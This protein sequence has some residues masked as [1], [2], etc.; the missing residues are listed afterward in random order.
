MSVLVLALALQATDV[1][2]IPAMPGPP[3]TPESMTSLAF[4]YSCSF[5][6]GNGRQLNILLERRGGRGFATGESKFPAR[7]TPYSVQV[8]HNNTGADV[9]GFSE[10]HASAKGSQLEL[11]TRD[12]SEI[13][14]ILRVSDD[15]SWPDVD[16][17]SRAAAS[18]SWGSTVD[19]GTSRWLEHR[20]EGEC[21][22]EKLV[23]EP[24]SATEANEFLS[25]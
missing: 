23:Q 9:E 6:D 3:P 10:I 4:N 16:L 17:D 1:R 12:G 22:L 15:W 14:A 11:I 8:L 5:A 19:N 18:L 21:A 2:V 25:K 24:L 7:R 13:A 20:L